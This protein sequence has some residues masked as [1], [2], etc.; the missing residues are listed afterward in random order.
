MSDLLT[1]ETFM[2][3][4]FT[5]DADG[6]EPPTPHRRAHDAACEAETASGQTD[7]S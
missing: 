1:S 6:T 7:W 3:H 5:V 2:D 4:V